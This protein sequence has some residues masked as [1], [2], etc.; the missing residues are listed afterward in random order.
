M[1][2][3]CVRKTDFSRPVLFETPSISQNDVTLEKPNKRYA[4]I[5]THGM[6]YVM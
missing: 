3:F 6:P 5:S 1:G 2:H 4:V